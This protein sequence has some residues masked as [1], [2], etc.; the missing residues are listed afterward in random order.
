ML[1]VPLTATHSVDLMDLGSVTSCPPP[2]SLQHPCLSANKL[3]KA[4]SHYPELT[5]QGSPGR[6]PPLPDLPDCTPS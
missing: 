6:P 1:C 5:L 4:W 3:F 2:L